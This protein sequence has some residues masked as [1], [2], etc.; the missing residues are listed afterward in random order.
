MAKR[1]R[2]KVIKL[3]NIVSNNYKSGYLK[4]KK[5]YVS[6]IGG[7]A[8]YNEMI[9]VRRLFIDMLRVQNNF[10]DLEKVV[11]YKN[12]FKANLSEPIY[13][14]YTSLFKDVWLDVQEFIKFNFDLLLNLRE[15]TIPSIILYK[16]GSTKIFSEIEYDLAFSVLACIS[17]YK[18]RKKRNDRVRK[19][20]GY[21][22]KRKNDKVYWTFDNVL[23][24]LK[25]EN[26][27]SKIF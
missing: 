12:I 1:R 2:S 20:K 16:C 17:F 13:A 24:S 5:K 26:E 7:K 27:N 3:F 22:K 4:A 23:D 11:G 25:I 21:N 6:L 14:K 15:V 10:N 9:F 18:W 19:Q 8:I